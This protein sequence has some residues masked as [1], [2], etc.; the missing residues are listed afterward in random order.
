MLKTADGI[1]SD[2]VPSYFL[3]LSLGGI[4]LE[5][6]FI[7]SIVF[8]FHFILNSGNGKEFFSVIFGYMKSNLPENEC[9]V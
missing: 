9:D 3:V 8:C 4:G 7:V 5:T 2:C 1:I 6:R